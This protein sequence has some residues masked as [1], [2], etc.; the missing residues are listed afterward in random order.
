MYICVRPPLKKNPVFNATQKNNVHL[1]VALLTE[2]V[3][4]CFFK[5]M[6]QTTEKTGALMHMVN[7]QNASINTLSAKCGQIIIFARLRDLFWHPLFLQQ[8]VIIQGPSGANC[9]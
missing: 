1:A 9:D 5:R 4:T 2:Q 3:C 6:K 8:R 7:G